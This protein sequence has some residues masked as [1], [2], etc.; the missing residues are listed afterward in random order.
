MSICSR[1]LC[2]IGL[3]K[4]RRDGQRRMASVS[5]GGPVSYN[6]RSWYLTC[7]RR[8]TLLHLHLLRLCPNLS[9]LTVRAVFFTPRTLE[10]L[11]HTNI[12]SLHMSYFEP[13]M[14]LTWLF[15]ALSLGLRVFDAYCAPNTAWPHQQLMNLLAWSKCPLERLIFCGLAVTDV[16]RTEYVAL[17]PSLVVHPIG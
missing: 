2:L 8:I 3:D 16:P 12:Q 7:V 5:I 4:V 10:Q 14:L 13:G 9:S 6:H 15:E 17:I 1:V 11:T